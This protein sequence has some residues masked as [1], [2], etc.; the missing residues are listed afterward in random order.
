ML[1][2]FA[3]IKLVS[4]Q[5]FN[6]HNSQRHL[7]PKPNPNCQ[8]QPHWRPVVCTHRF[9]AWCFSI[10]LRYRH[11]LGHILPILMSWLPKCVTFVVL[12]NSIEISSSTFE[13]KCGLDS[14]LELSKPAASSRKLWVFCYENVKVLEKSLQSGHRRP[15][16]VS[17]LERQ[18]T[19][20]WSFSKLAHDFSTNR[21][22]LI[23]PSSY[24]SSPIGKSTK[25][26]QTWRPRL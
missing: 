26:P 18:L 15:S 8:Q 23:S 11:G 9:G 25:L 21:I 5:L 19:C 4:L 24:V 7:W 10:C 16:M 22:V 2:F 20:N 14:F 3:E 6:R 13:T 1:Y 12:V 17:F